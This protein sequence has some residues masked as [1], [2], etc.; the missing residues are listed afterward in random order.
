M[1][2]QGDDPGLA[3]VIG[4]RR[5]LVALA[6]RMLGTMA[7]AEDAVQETY[8]RWYRMSEEERAGVVNVQGWLTRVAS[9]V[10][11]DVLKSARV[12][13]EQYVGPWLP[14]P[15]PAG[16]ATDPADRATLDDSVSTALLV[17]LEAMTPAERVAFVLHDVFGV[18]FPEIAEVVGRSPA[19]V[20][21][22]ATSARR[23]VH[24]S[25]ERLAPAAE[26][27]AVVRAFAAAC[28]GGDLSALLAVLD[29]SV[30]LRSDGGGVVRAAPKPILG[31]EKVARF[32][33]GILLKRPEW[34]L[35]LRETPDGLAV[36][37]EHGDAVEGIVNL[38]VVD[39]RVHDVWI[40]LNPAKLS[41]W[42]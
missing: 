20:R 17:V 23:R 27:S 12:R 11:L 8:I 3:G 1:S 40:M 9:H 19:A 10:C 39:G 15:L 42:A 7:E 4:E 6:Y 26:H 22:L 32:I 31:A 34:R 28:A 35:G 2:E 37:F 29:P 16:E 21:Q 14:E 24:A 36:A 13:R 25:R 38:G 18:S 30:E 33:A 41:R 5:R